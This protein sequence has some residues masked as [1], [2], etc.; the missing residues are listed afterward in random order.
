[1]AD[2]DLPDG[3]GD[4]CQCHDVS[5]DGRGNVLDSV[6][7]ARATASLL[8]D[9]AAP[10]KCSG[11]GPAAC[12]AGDVASLR[13]ALATPAPPPVASCLAS[14]ACTASADCPAGVSCDLAAQL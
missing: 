10:G 1:V 9:L 12:D 8:P 7:S 5:D 6:L 2:P 4:A 11:P 13:T 14:G 3:I